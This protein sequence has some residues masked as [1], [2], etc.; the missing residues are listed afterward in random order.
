M[1]HKT[2]DSVLSIQ[3]SKLRDNKYNYPQGIIILQIVQLVNKQ[4][5]CSSVEFE[6]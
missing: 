3:N 4:L 5:E 6:V 1:H 2:P